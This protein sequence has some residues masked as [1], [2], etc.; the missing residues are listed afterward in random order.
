MFTRQRRP[1]PRRKVWFAV[2]VPLALMAAGAGIT[3]WAGYHDRR[4]ASAL[5]V[6][7][8]LF[9]LGFA[10]LALSLSLRL[11]SRKAVSDSVKFLFL[12]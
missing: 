3:L 7:V 8:M 9:G 4:S 6:G 2:A 10:A 11:T 5:T 12:F 1:S